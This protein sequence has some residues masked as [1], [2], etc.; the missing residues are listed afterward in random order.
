M[1]EVV[2]VFFWAFIF[3]QWFGRYM[4]HFR[5][6]FHGS[7]SVRDNGSGIARRASK[8]RDRG[9]SSST[10]SQEPPLP[11]ISS[12]SPPSSSLWKCSRHRLV[13]RRPK[14]ALPSKRARLVPRFG[15][16][17]GPTRIYTPP[18]AGPLRAVTALAA[19]PQHVFFFIGHSAR[20]VPRQAQQPAQWGKK[21][22]ILFFLLEELKCICA[23]NF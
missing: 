6:A 18:A 20:P 5:A 22:Y 12:E 15:R 8:R 3:F 11:G 13:R 2:G 21:G 14:Y 23:W 1:S 9:V 16:A 19:G 10:A 17:A 7:D 4:G